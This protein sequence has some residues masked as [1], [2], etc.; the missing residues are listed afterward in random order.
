M[1]NLFILFT[2]LM[3]L[4]VSGCSEYD[5]SALT[6][7]MDNLEDRVAKLE[8]LCKQM[9]T[10]ISSLQT[11][12]TALQNNDYVTRVIPVTQGGKEIGYTITFTK[13]D[14]ITIYH[15]E[16]GETGATGN[17]G[18]TPVIGVRQDADGIYYWTL[19]GEW[20]TE[21]GSKIKA[22]GTDGTNGKSAYELA[23]EKGYSGT[24]EEWL[25]SLK[26]NNGTSGN[27]GK[28]AYEL[29]VEKGYRGT[30]DEWLEDLQGET[31][32]K[33]ESGITPK[34]KIEN[35][36]WYVSYDKENQMWEQL[37]KATD[38]DG[39]DGE[40]IFSDVDYKTSSD[41]VV[42]TLADGTKLTIP[43]TESRLFDRLQS[44]IYIPKYADGKATMIRTGI[45]ETIAGFDFRVSPKEVA[46]E[47]A[48]AWQ[49]VLSMQAVYTLATRTVSH[50]D[51]PI[52]SCEADQTE[53]M[54]SITVSGENL[55]E[56]FFDGTQS[57]SVSL[58]V[59]DGNDEISSA[60]IPIL[61]STSNEIWY[62]SANNTVVD[63][64]NKNFGADI[65]SNTIENGK[66][67]IRFDGPVTEIGVKAFAECSNLT[68]I[69]IPESVTKIDSLAF[70]LCSGLT[71]ITLPDNVTSIGGFAFSFCSNLTSITI[72]QSITSIGPKAFIFCEK[73]E[74]FHGKYA[75]EDHRALVKDG[76]FLAF[77]PAG[78]TNYSIPE[79]VTSVG[80]GAF[81]G[82]NKL[83]G[84]VT[85][86]EGVTSIEDD[87]FSAC[88]NLK[89]ITIPNSITSI[90]AG[91]FANC[92]ILQSIT[93][94]KS[95]VTIGADTFSG[96]SR[97]TSI[98]I[99]EGVTEIGDRA[100]WSCSGLTSIDIPES[101]TS[102]GEF[103][104][105]STPLT[106]ITIPS[107]VTEIGRWAFAYCSLTSVTIPENVVKLGG[108]IFPECH[109]L[110]AFHGKY[111]SEDH[112]AL[113]K[114]G[115]LLSFAPA[116]LT[117]YSIPEGITSIGD[118][119]FQF[120][121]D[122]T[123]ITI[124][125]GVTSIGNQVFGGCFAL[126]TLYCKPTLPPSFED[127]FGEF[128]NTMDKIYVPTTSVEVYKSAPGW[129]DYADRIVGYDF[130]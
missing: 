128:P 37:G 92:R 29:A 63:P 41:Y 130:N 11:I 10:N 3:L 129:S 6:G 28:S 51:M 13:S 17:D 86:P 38:E 66:G 34:L 25:E 120:C 115:I 56:A 30:L 93:I 15:G 99:P 2:V 98:T 48:A 57:A 31:G 105:Q 20:L 117:E 107:S 89:S 116:G 126:T 54:I 16:K 87:T 36:Y 1:K 124:P 102:I 73:L 19:D 32:Q 55:S 113:I 5:D 90:G 64:T 4:S 60:Y 62:T 110:Q 74:A 67:V 79:G 112:R 72:P 50:I 122:L 24:E 118:H 12:V 123:N 88:T 77:A 81:M 58:C 42:F 100:F 97:L 39:A 114:D 47:I 40:P 46:A 82:C 27:D 84:S 103:A 96:C 14:P 109:N 45:E 71:S 18:H 119:V 76:V 95:V 53:G 52:L 78:M 68:N 104:F 9:N 94:P 69:A 108:N 106:N 127:N 85:I 23:V 125:E 83:T 44:L 80:T 33:G 111:A 22:Q 21:G 65:L 121:T 91:A 75:T 70:Q 61:F 35:G 7:R 26:G 49:S 101:V 59:S 8:E 43:T